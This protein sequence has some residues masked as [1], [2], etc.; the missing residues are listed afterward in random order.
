MGGTTKHGKRIIARKG[1]GE[2]YARSNW[3]HGDASQVVTSKQGLM[4]VGHNHIT[5]NPLKVLSM[6][7]PKTREANTNVKHSKRA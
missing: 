6:A 5:T 4:G 7:K 1:K 3:H 2:R